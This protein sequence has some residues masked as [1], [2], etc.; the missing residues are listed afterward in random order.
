MKIERTGRIRRV[1]KKQVKLTDYIIGITW[2]LNNIIS[3]FIKVYLTYDIILVSDVQH[4]ELT[5]IYITKCS[6]Q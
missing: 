3:F 6:P 4:S 1:Y 2:K 5:I